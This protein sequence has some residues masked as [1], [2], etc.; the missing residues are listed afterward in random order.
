MESIARHLLSGS[1][2]G[3]VEHEEAPTLQ[4]I[5]DD[6]PDW[7]PPLYIVGGIFMILTLL[8]AGVNI[9][10]HLVVGREEATYTLFIPAH[11]II[12]VIILF[13]A[14]L[15][16]F[17]SYFAIWAPRISHV[18]ELVHNFYEAI[19]LA[20]FFFLML[21][22][23]RGP[24]NGLK[25]MEET[26]PFKLRALPPFCCCAGCIR[27]QRMD[28]PTLTLA[29][30]TVLQFVILK[31]MLYV[32]QIGL[33]ING[34]NYADTATYFDGF[35]LLQ[36]VICMYG[37]FMLYKAAS[38]VLPEFGLGTKFVVIKAVIV[39]A[40]LQGFI[41]KVS[42]PERDCD[43]IFSK[44]VE[45]EIWNNFLF[46]IEFCLIAVLGYK[47]FPVHELDHIVIDEHKRKEM[48]KEMMPVRI[49]ME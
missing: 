4:E 2:S 5:M 40:A 36:T 46:C 45:G 30:W 35:N 11:R 16:A 23:M 21:Y 26:P 15:Y 39:I 31:P 12:V 48:E 6:T 20:A 17:T 49:E 27:E 25:L 24:V 14:P 18:V 1:S 37:L 32:F 38:P 19:A 41:L 9:V 33:E 44:E 29:R 13:M 28:A 34:Y 22:I 7:L 42:I 3:C 8:I 47:A 43:E 10:A